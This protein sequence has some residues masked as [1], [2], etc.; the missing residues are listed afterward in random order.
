MQSKTCAVLKYNAEALICIMLATVKRFTYSCQSFE[1][2]QPDSG[3]CKC[4]Y[5]SGNKKS[6][7]G[8][9]E[10]DVEISVFGTAQCV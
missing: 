4:T 9:L 3:L 6:V 10:Q 5:L 8:V 7:A 2:E 1:I